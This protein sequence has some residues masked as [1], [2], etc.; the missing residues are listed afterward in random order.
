MKAQIDSLQTSRPVAGF[1]PSALLVAALA[2]LAFVFVG[3]GT[4]N[5][6]TASNNAAPE[7]I[8]PEGTNMFRL[9]PGATVKVAFEGDTNMTTVTKIQMDGNINLPFT[10]DV[11]ASG[12]TLDEL[13]K[14]LSSRYESILKLSEITVTLLDSGFT[15]T[16]SGAVMK[17]GR[18]AM[19]RPIT[20]LEAISD[21]GGHDPNRAKLNQVTV[22]RVENGKQKVYKINIKRVMSGQEAPFYLKPFDVIHVPEKVW[23]L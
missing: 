23:N 13:K 17:P 21:A 11:K 2:L 20:A 10:G 19:D 14:D 22:L 15:V 6:S 9:S 5:Q 4:T 16:V 12:K 7:M 1:A 3:C 18:V 8:T